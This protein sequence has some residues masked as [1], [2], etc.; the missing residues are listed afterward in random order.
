[1][2][3]VQKGLEKAPPKPHSPGGEPASC[4]ACRRSLTKSGK[5]QQGESNGRRSE[6][7]PPRHFPKSR[8]KAEDPRHGVPGERCEAAGRDHL[9]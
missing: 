7:K 4:P 6:A 5:E 1:M 3:Q 9:V 8:Q 2:S